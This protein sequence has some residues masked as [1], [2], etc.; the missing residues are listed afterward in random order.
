MQDGT[1]IEIKGYKNGKDSRKINNF[2]YRLK[3]LYYD[4]MKPYMDYMKKRYGDDVTKIYE[5][6]II[7]RFFK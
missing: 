4:Q 3:V 6:Y 1:F 7:D 2:P 5:T